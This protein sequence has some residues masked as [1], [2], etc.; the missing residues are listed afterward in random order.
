MDHPRC[1]EAANLLLSL[2]KEGPVPRLS[3]T[4]PNSEKKGLWLFADFD[5]NLIS[6]LSEKDFQLN[7][8]T[9]SLFAT[10]VGEQSLTCPTL[11]CDWFAAKTLHLLSLVRDC[12]CSSS[13]TRK[14]KFVSDWSET[15]LVHN[16]QERKSLFEKTLCRW[17]PIRTQ[18]PSLRSPCLFCSG[19][20]NHSQFQQQG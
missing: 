9:S 15:T 6:I 14:R 2:E 10:G 8:L 18:S 7:F 13:I 16:Y 5:R 17:S 20:E 4:L 1:L 3:S 11:P 19:C 12:Y